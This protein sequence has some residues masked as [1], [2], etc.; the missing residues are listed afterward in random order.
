MDKIK[1]PHLDQKSSVFFSQALLICVKGHNSHS[2]TLFQ[3]KKYDNSVN[4]SPRKNK[5]IHVK[6]TF[7]SKN[8]LNRGKNAYSL[9]LQFL[10]VHRSPGLQTMYEVL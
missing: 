2:K 7:M 3:Q 8:K 1:H 6:L 5:T 4:E 10:N 9:Q